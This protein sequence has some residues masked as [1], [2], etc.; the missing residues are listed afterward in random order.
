MSF[1]QQASQHR[2]QFELIDPG[3]QVQSMNLNELSAGLRGGRFK[4]PQAGA[5]ASSATSAIEGR[6]RYLNSDRA[7]DVR[8]RGANLTWVVSPGPGR[9][10]APVWPEPVPACRSEA[11]P[12][13]AV[14]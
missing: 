12:G 3:K 4:A 13:R 2:N 9:E 14:R 7:P 10:P 11:I 6:T 8:V 1:S 5:S